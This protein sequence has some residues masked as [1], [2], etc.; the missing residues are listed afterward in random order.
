MTTCMNMAETRSLNRV[1]YRTDNL[2]ACV[3]VY[4]GVLTRL[5][6]CRLLFCAFLV[7]LHVR[8][9]NASSRVVKA[10]GQPAFDATTE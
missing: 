5:A 1:E 2:H 4:P 10:I 3:Y 8:I 7:L 9:D 6:P